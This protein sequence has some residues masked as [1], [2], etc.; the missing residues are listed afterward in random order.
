MKITAIVGSLIFLGLIIYILS[1]RKEGFIMGSPFPYS[2]TKGLLA[3]PF[4]DF[5]MKKRDTQGNRLSKS[6]YVS[7]WELY[8]QTPAGSYSQ[9][10]NNKQYWDTPCNGTTT[11][12]EM[13]GGFY[14]KR[15]VKSHPPL[16]Y[17]PL[18][19]QTGVRVNYYV[20]GK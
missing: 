18:S 16:P 13:C 4:G 5:T 2:V 6:N 15:K 3:P 1:K 8:P 10:T 11:P 9:V 20:S 12:T 19:P 14:N 7:A 17:P